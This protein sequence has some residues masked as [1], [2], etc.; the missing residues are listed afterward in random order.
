[1]LE[2]FAMTMQL[3]I[4]QGHPLPQVVQE[5]ED[6]NPRLIVGT[7]VDAFVISANA[8][9]IGKAVGDLIVLPEIKVTDGRMIGGLWFDEAECSQALGRDFL[10]RCAVCEGG[11]GWVVAALTA[12]VR[13]CHLVVGQGACVR[14][15]VSVVMHS[16]C[17]SLC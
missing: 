4:Q 17:A 10:K 1:M 6:A 3:S 8:A 2:V 9:P 16:T 7:I 14:A 13:S 11:V 5:F 12:A 15:L